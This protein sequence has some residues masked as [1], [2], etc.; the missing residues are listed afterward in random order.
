MKGKL[1]AKSIQNNSVKIDGKWY[2]VS[3]NI[4]DFLEKI[5][6]GLVD[7]SVKNNIITFLKNIDEE[8]QEI[9]TETKK[10]EVEEE[11][12]DIT[13]EIWE[14]KDRR[15]ARMS[16]LKCATDLVRTMIEK[17]LINK[18]FTETIIR[19]ARKFENYVYEEDIP[20]SGGDENQ[21]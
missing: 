3:N 6:Y 16:V 12:I 5:D 11:K 19:I 4:V 18:D 15:I 7:Y 10:T 14:K 9:T 1:T 20:L 17:D 2:K 13:S 21:N 8:E